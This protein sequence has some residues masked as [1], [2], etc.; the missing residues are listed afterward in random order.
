MNEV[1]AILFSLTGIIFGMVLS[2]ISP[3]EMLVGKKYF[4]LLKRTFFVL[5]SLFVLYNFYTKI[6]LLVLFLILSI[7]LF[8]LDIKFENKYFQVLHYILFLTPYFFIIDENKLVLVSLVFLYGFPSGTLLR[9]KD[10]R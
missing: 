9:I 10:E 3:E 1:L 8:V 5:I 7:I 6:Y 4:L 2:V